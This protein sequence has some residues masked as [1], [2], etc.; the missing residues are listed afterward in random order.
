MTEEERD[1]LIDRLPDDMNVWEFED[2]LD[3]FPGRDWSWWR[4]QLGHPHA[5]GHG[6]CQTCGPGGPCLLAVFHGA[7]ITTVVRHLDRLGALAALDGD[8][9]KDQT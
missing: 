4:A 5:T 6:Y 9:P 7:L 2:E 8:T 1:D 3:H